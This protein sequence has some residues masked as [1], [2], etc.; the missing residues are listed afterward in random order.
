MSIPLRRRIILSIYLLGIIADA[1]WT[2]ALLS[3]PFF[4]F[5]T[6]RV[7]TDPSLL[8]RMNMSIGA[9]LMAGWTV[10]LGWSAC[11]PIERRGVLLITFFPVLT[12]LVTLTMI[13]ISSGNVNSLWILGK[14]IVLSGAMLTGYWMANTVK[15]EMKNENDNVNTCA[16]LSY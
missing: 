2:V 10:L 14:C 9:S 3:P 7:M 4:G 15:Q 1:V 11:D 13:G 6:G 5:L 8:L 12:G 16:Q